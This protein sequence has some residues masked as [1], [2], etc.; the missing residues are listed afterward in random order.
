[1]IR[2]RGFVQYQAFLPP[3]TAE[4]GYLKIL[5]HLISA[6]FTSFLSVFK[7]CGAGRV[8]ILS[9]LDEGY[10]LAL[11]LPNLGNDLRK[12]TIELDNI[13]IENGGR[14]Y[15]AKDALTTKESFA[16]MYPR[17]ERFKTIKAEID[18]R[19]RIVSDQARRLGIVEAK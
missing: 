7:S 1:M 6:G 3:Q 4:I 19:Q 15:M 11:D 12:L 9:F 17:L 10:T 18:P 14:L 8:G 13:L 5:E 16:A 2:E